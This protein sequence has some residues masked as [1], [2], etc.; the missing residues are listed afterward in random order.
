[1]TFRNIAYRYVWLNT[2]N[3]YK[4]PD[5]KYIVLTPYDM[6]KQLIFELGYVEDERGNNI[7]DTEMVI[8]PD[9]CIPGQLAMSAQLKA[10]IEDQGT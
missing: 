4:Y 5:W 8:L 9:H 3:L 6:T 10:L 2:S 1:M 7:F